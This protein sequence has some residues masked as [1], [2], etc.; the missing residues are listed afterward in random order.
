MHKHYSYIFTMAIDVI[1]HRVNMFIDDRNMNGNNFKAYASDMDIIVKN[2][3]A[4]PA[5]WT[6]HLQKI[7]Y[8]I[9]IFIVPLIGIGQLANVF[10]ANPI[11]NAQVQGNKAPTL[12]V[13]EMTRY[14]EVFSHQ[15]LDNIVN[16]REDEYIQNLQFQF[17]LLQKLIILSIQHVLEG[18]KI[19]TLIDLVGMCA[20]LPYTCALA[21][22][23]AKKTFANQ[24]IPISDTMNIM[25]K[26]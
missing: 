22:G 18:N 21:I 20:A 8:F 10:L 3:E 7:Q 13:L 14:A 25:M 1:S 9:I 5:L 6:L 24:P 2:I 16:S 12:H 17:L 11:A 26:Y 19:E 15:F 4:E 23:F